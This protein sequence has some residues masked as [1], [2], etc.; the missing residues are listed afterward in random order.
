MQFQILSHAGLKV[1]AQGV[2]LVCDPWLIG[3][4]YWRSWWNYPPVPRALVESLKPDFIYLTHIHWD[5]FH[6]PSLRLFD[7]ATP[8]IIPYDRYERFSKDLRSIGFS[9][10][11]EL[12]NG[13]SHALAPGFTL[14]SY[15]FAPFVTD[16]AVV[17]E[18]DGVTILN[19]NDAKLA[20]GP[21]DHLLRAH[22]KIDIA[23]RSH[24]S[25]NAHANFHVMGEEDVPQDDNSRYLHSFSLFMNRVKPRYAIPFASNNCL[26]HDESFAYNRLVQ[27]PVAVRDYFR[28]FAADHG[29]ATEIQIMVPG[30]SWSPET[31]FALSDM[32]WFSDRDAH[33][34]AYRARVQPTMQRQAAMEAR[35][36]VPL[37]AV[38]GF[39]AKLSA[40]LPG[41]LRR[42]MDY[43]VLMVAK[44]ARGTDGFA[45]NLGTGTVAAVA[46]ADFGNFDKRIEFPAL[47]LLQSLRMN[48]FGHA[49]I[50]RRV[51]FFAARAE[52]PRLWR[53]L[54]VLDWSEA[55]MFPLS[56][57]FSRR[58]LRAALPRWREGLLY[59]GVATQVAR[60]R[61]LEHIEANLLKVG[62]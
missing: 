18:A 23:L 9:N 2:Q 45:V 24:S 60:G 42:R 41:P 16:S 57:H 32:D 44:S 28:A 51:N 55:E 47:V 37:S 11:I 61:S 46:E 48:M 10:I 43:T 33:I 15:H 6:G 31:G 38:T 59:A 35:V 25:A 30:D 7:R 5:H 22:P 40:Q 62:N 29:L 13:E 4:A 39:V 52:L 17:I 8:V 27:T 49:A 56:R 26:L 14:T 36:S 54:N 3:S 50:C 58:S 1:E 12:R 53:F 20:G 21:L 34:A 19:A